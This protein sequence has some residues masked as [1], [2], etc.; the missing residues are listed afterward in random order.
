MASFRL[1]AD[2]A[3]WTLP[4]WSQKSF[5]PSL[6]R[7]DGPDWKNKLQLAHEWLWT[8]WSYVKN[9]EPFKLGRGEVEQ[10]PGVI[11][12]DVSQALESLVEQLPS[13]TK[14]PKKA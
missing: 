4:P 8:K 10:S 9:T 2:G 1:D 5:G 6:D 12:D 14:Y 7:K 3:D 13:K 11:K